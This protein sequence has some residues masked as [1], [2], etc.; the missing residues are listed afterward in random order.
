[1]ALTSDWYC[2]SQNTKNSDGRANSD[3][4][5]TAVNRQSAA[6][7][8]TGVQ[9]DDARSPSGLNSV[10]KFL[11]PRSLFAGLSHTLFGVSHTLFGV[12]VDRKWSRLEVAKREWQSLSTTSCGSTAHLSLR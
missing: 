6:D 2:K 8:K 12:R 9:K 7:H 10:E 4:G 3:L 1:M 5:P 11:H